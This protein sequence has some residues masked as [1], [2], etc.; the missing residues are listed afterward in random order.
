MPAK[1]KKVRAVT[2]RDFPSELYWRAKMCAA[3]R[4]MHFKAYV[5]AA[6]EEATQKDS[7]NLPHRSAG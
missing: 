6:L 1:D 7:K 5:I 4:E 3:S 2:L